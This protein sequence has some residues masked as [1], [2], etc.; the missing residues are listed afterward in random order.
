MAIR[1][2]C[3][4]SVRMAIHF[5]VDF[6]IFKWVHDNTILK[7]TQNEQQHN[8]NAENLSFNWLQALK[9]SILFLL[10]A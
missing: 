10:Q 1:T 9:I 7:H 3:S 8:Y 2:L 5:F 4:D 6:D